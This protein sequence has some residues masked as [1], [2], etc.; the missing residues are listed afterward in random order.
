M[1]ERACICWSVCIR[2]CVCVYVCLN[3]PRSPERVWSALS[4][5]FVLTINRYIKHSVYGAA[6]REKDIG[7]TFYILQVLSESDAAGNVIIIQYTSKQ[8]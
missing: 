6:A 4:K 1:L 5:I 8:Y 2:V 3:R 7:W